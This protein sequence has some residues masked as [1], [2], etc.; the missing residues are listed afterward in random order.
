MIAHL[1]FPSNNP[2][3]TA[4]FFAALIDGIV[5]D[6]PVVPGAAVAV[7]RDGSGT[8]VEVYPPAMKHHP[9]SGR[10]DPN[11]TPDG[12]AAMPWEDQIFAEP[13]AD[14]PSTFHLALETRLS[15]AEVLRLAESRGWRSLACERG[16]VF[17]VVEVWVDNL[18]LVEVLVPE[19]AER[20]RAFMNP[21]G[22]AAMF[23]P[24]TLPQN[25]DADA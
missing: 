6:F 16:G 23:G 1:S 21:T 8:A 19:Q 12:P 10:V 14:G 24:G 25:H 4:L 3:A 13:S 9:G 11:L 17:G 2:K 5:F 20:Y 18:H 15:E 7:A 22:C